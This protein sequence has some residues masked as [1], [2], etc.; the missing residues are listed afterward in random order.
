M[1]ESVYLAYMKTWLWSMLLAGYGVMA[2][3]GSSIRLNQVGFYTQGPKVAVV[4]AGKSADFYVVTASDH[5]RVFSGRLQAAR[6]IDYSPHTMQLADFSTLREAGRYQVEVPGLGYSAPFDIGHHVYHTLAKASVKAFYYHRLS[7]DIPPA[8]AGMWHRPRAHEDN[9]VRVHASAATPRRPE[10][11]VIRSPRGWYDAGDY[12]KYI[13]NS[14]ITMSTLMSASADF[15]A[16]T[17]T[18]HLNLPPHAAV[19]DLVDE[20]LWNLRWMLTM[21][22]PDDG[23]VYHKLTN[24]KFDPMV[25][26]HAATTPRYVV[27][28]STAATLDFAAVMAQASRWLQ[29]HQRAL[30]GLADSCLRA[31]Q[32]AWQWAKQHPQV[33]YNQEAMNRAYDPDVVTGGYGDQDVS[34]EWLWASILLYTQTGDAQYLPQSLL[35]DDKMPLPSWGQVRLLGYYDILRYP[36]RW[37]AADVA[38]IKARL[39]READKLVTAATQT[40]YATPM[41]S[42]ARDFVW[43]SNAVAANQGVLLWQAYSLTQDARYRTAAL[44]NLD[45]ILGRNATGY[46]YVTGFGQQ[47]VMHPHHRPS[48]ADGVVAPV[49]GWL[50]GGANPG[51]QDKCVYPS[52]VPDEAYVDDDRSYA[53]NEVAINWNAP[54]VYLV[55][56]AEAQEP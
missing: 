51:K 26:P 8:Y 10:G 40:P 19:P 42:T 34:D 36:H 6:T 39:L 37:P 28:K 44:A 31:A 49:P 18:L 32:Q 50:A 16:Y 52:S 46:C 48:I 20:I 43:G 47:P 41:G 14:G 23:G 45:Y 25:M 22:D 15:A 27:M 35:P 4:P 1:M 24:A 13:V 56:A 33:I 5:R 29:P 30:P 54:L 3:Q 7:T 21:Q 38:T 11:T 53:S 55:M 17:D 12:N 2:Q 9:T